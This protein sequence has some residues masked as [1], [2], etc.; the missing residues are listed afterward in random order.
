MRRDG[1]LDDL[2][3][4]R[5]LRRAVGAAGVAA[6]AAAA[7]ARRRA[8]ALDHLDLAEALELGADL[9]RGSHR[10]HRQSLRVDPAAYAAARSAAL[11]YS[12]RSR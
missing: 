9:A 10:H 7:P 5:D 4:A 2:A 3:A 1:A 8:V 12:S 11:S 6:A